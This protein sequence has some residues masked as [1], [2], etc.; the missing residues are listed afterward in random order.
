MS[1][2]RIQ[3]RD[4]P[5]LP[6][7]IDESGLDPIRDVGRFVRRDEFDSREALLDT[8]DEFQAVIVR[9]LDV[10]R[11]F[12]ERPTN[13]RVVAKHGAGLDNVDVDAATEH[14]V[15]VLTHRRRTPDPSRNTPSRSF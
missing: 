14:G 3:I 2:L 4:E 11:S 6:P 9:T 13:L 10:N 12:V 5:I 8:I 15:V 7:R 1:S